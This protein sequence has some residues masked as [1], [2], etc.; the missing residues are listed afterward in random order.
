MTTVRTSAGWLAI[1][2]VAAAAFLNGCGAETE[3]EFQFY[4]EKYLTALLEGTR[5]GYAG[6]GMHRA[7][8]G[9]AVSF[10]RVTDT[11][12]VICRLDG[13]TEAIAHPE[14]GWV[15]LDGDLRLRG[16]ANDSGFLVMD[17]GTGIPLGSDYARDP[18]GR[19]FSVGNRIYAFEPG[20]PEIYV[21]PEEI[22]FIAS[23]AE[24]IWVFRYRNGWWGRT[25]S[26]EDGAVE[27]LETFGIAKS[28]CTIQDMNVETGDVMLQTVMDPPLGFLEAGYVF[29]VHTWR[30]RKVHSGSGVALYL[31]DDVLGNITRDS[32]LRAAAGKR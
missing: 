24:R 25:L 30:L 11:S 5:Y 15:M 14:Q 22:G 17:D 3:E 29:N 21:V 12:H 20:Y 32:I 28:G 7:S 19:Y 18:N 23:S 16:C 6:G 2:L 1:V 10:E 13:S 4:S 8:D 26:V 9:K 31:K 27:E